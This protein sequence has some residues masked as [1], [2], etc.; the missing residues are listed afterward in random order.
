MLVSTAQIDDLL[1]FITL[2]RQGYA[3]YCNESVCLSLRLSHHTHTS[4]TTAQ[5]NC[6]TLIGDRMLEVEPLSLS[7]QN[8]N[9]AVA[10]RR[11]R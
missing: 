1:V 8:G 10:G 4:S 7:G 5:F 3:V 6:R 11:I 2:P 9:E